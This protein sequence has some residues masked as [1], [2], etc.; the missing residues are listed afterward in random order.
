M[1]IVSYA[2]NFEDV[3]LWRALH[4]V[5]DGFYIDVGANHPVVDSVNQAFHER[6]WTGFHIEPVPEYAAAL[7]EARPDGV[8]IEAVVSEVADL[9]TFYEVEGTGLSTLERSLADR[10][11]AEGRSVRRHHKSS[12]TLDSI[13]QQRDGPIHWLK[14]DVEGHEHAALAGWNTDVR[15]WVLVIESTQPLSEIEVV[16]D[17]E[18][19]VLAKGYRFAW[20][21]GLNRFYV[22]DD[23]PE[24]LARFGTP[25]NVFDRFELSG[26]ATA[27]FA[28]L[29]VKRVED[30][31][32]QAAEA[33]SKLDEDRVWV[34][35]HIA[36]LEGE[37]A[38]AVGDLNS[39]LSIA[40]EKLLAAEKGL[41]ESRAETLRN[42]AEL[43]R[44]CDEAML[45]ATARI[46]EIQDE[47]TKVN[48]A[49]AARLD[50]LHSILQD[51]GKSLEAANRIGLEQAILAADAKGE[52]LGL[53]EQ[54][55]ALQTRISE[56]TQ[57]VEQ[58]RATESRF[59]DRMAEQ[60]VQIEAM[61]SALAGGEAV[62]Q[63]LHEA[64]RR[65]SDEAGQRARVEQDLE[66]ARRHLADEAARIA[67]LEQGLEE[68][69]HRL[70]DGVER[71]ET[72]E[73]DLEGAQRRLA[74]EAARTE[75]LEQNLE[76]AERR[77]AD[78]A[79]RTEALEQDFEAAERRLSDGTTRI[80]AIQEELRVVEQESAAKQALASRVREDFERETVALTQALSD[81]RAAI[82]ERDWRVAVA[83]E[84]ARLLQHRLSGLET[85]YGDLQI[86]LQDAIESREQFSV[87]LVQAHERIGALVPEA[88]RLAMDLADSD[89][90]LSALQRSAAEDGSI[91]NAMIQGLSEELTQAQRAITEA[92]DPDELL[93]LEDEVSRLNVLMN[94]RRPSL[95]A[96]VFSVFGRRSSPYQNNDFQD[97]DL[98]LDQREGKRHQIAALLAPS[99]ELVGSDASNT[100]GQQRMMRGFITFLGRPAVDGYDKKLEK[101]D[102]ALR[103]LN[104]RADAIG[105]SV[106]LVK[107][108]VSK[109]LTRVAPPKHDLDAAVAERLS[110][111]AAEVFNALTRTTRSLKD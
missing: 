73:R 35:A 30:A 25:P 72:L 100:K 6:G 44:A 83:D 12:V 90:R 94:L 21:D 70:A 64:E 107:A 111:D 16:N 62:R 79:A 103:N 71:A 85:E 61:A 4:D 110:G 109:I 9:V 34:A 92:A 52:A 58:M 15:P 86:R 1:S 98:A 7:R 53:K 69:R 99:A 78:E 67:A 101:V 59:Q 27:T 75:A 43:R 45:G 48:A 37:H 66:E 14:I 80:A 89:A 2:Q 20:F 50:Q 65:V 105:S 93:R 68:A 10:Y 56:D 77:L 32:A 18:P 57:R 49:H 17:W 60:A 87:Q 19:D 5:E 3:L 106:D 11:E 54:I 8:V 47:L 108:D 26:D 88:A 63:R 40:R 81:H 102:Q 13:F 36:R 24:I 84:A 46:V 91:K 51:Y 29:L 38:A 55:S 95:L 33:S 28:R 96:I 41:V 74:D 22:R 82:A 23:K 104:D 97:I 39:E 31:R 42:D 76:A